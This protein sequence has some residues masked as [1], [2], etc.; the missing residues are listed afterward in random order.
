MP[1]FFHK[2][3]P[4]CFF[5]FA[6]VLCEILFNWVTPPLQSPDEFNHFYRAYQISEGY[7][8]PQQKHSRL[9]GDI[10]YD[11]S[12]FVAP[13]K[14]ASRVPELRPARNGHSDSFP[15]AVSNQSAFRD[16]PNTSYYC[17]VSYLPQALIL[18]VFK[19][20]SV[21][22]ATLYYA[23]RIFMFLVC[24]FAMAFVI[25]IMPVYKWLFTL[26]ALLPMNLFIMNSFSAD[27]VTN[28][29]SFL[30]IALVIKSVFGKDKITDQILIWLVVIAGLLA[31]AK[32][33]Y[34]ALIFLLF[35]IPGQK[36]KSVKQRVVAI[37][38]VFGVSILFFLFWSS[39]V[40]KNYLLYDEYA[41]AYR[42]AATIV[43][44]A[45][46]Y[47][48]KAYILNH[49]TYFPK[50]I[51]NTVSNPDKT[52]LATYIGAFGAF[53]DVTLPLWLIVLSYGVIIF[54]A[55]SE[56][57]ELRF[58]GRQRLVLFIAAFSCFVL[59]LLSQ[60]LTWDSVGSGRVELLQGRYFAPLFPLIFMAL[61]NP[62]PKLKFKVAAMVVVSVFCLMAFSV[63]ALYERYIS[64]PY[65]DVTVITCGAEQLDE[66]GNY[67]TSSPGVYL[68]GRSNQ[69][70]VE[71][72]NGNYSAVVSP[73]LPYILTYVFKG[74]HTGDL[75]DISAWQ[76]GDATLCVLGGKKECGDF[77]N[78]FSDVQYTDRNGWI[79]LHGIFV[80][81]SSC[82][83]VNVGFFMRS[84]SNQTAYV[85]DLTFKLKRKLK[86]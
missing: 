28:I 16:F 84:K 43:P 69:T 66:S 57:N 34:V 9:G 52:Y 63:W 74:F 68:E 42:N 35:L 12:D 20:S 37:S 7:F 48:Q 22:T 27:N 5:V 8:L 51:C 83:T 78:E 31:L 3:K 30:F 86:P 21:S 1:D 65:D 54:V 72:R 41:P 73:A 53:L 76:K 82:D 55:F 46:Y 29:L 50:V 45:N 33:V 58:S 40:M 38:S 71:K 79:N 39:V 10:P 67:K 15:N 61:G 6:A 75:I 2:I 32:L 80:I 23:G 47:E 59:L 81:D 4:H 11:V 36:F 13:F 14:M 25:K 64:D 19:Q 44:E 60:H 85:D 18:F 26:L 62:F 70:S 17:P 24:L 56:K 77:Y 49:P